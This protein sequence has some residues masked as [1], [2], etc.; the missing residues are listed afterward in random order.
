MVRSSFNETGFISNSSLVAYFDGT[1]N[2]ETNMEVVDAINGALPGVAHRFLHD[3]LYVGVA[4]CGYGDE[5]DE[6]LID[7]SQYNVSWLPDVKIYGVN[8]TVGTSLLR[9]QFGDRRDV[10]IALESMGNVLRMMLGGEDNNEEEYEEL[11]EPEDV[12]DGG[13]CQQTTPPEYQPDMDFEKLEKPDEVP[14]LEEN[15]EEDE[16][17]PELDKEEEKPKLDEGPRKPKLAGGE[18][19]AELDGGPRENKRIDRVAGFDS[20]ASKRRGGGALMGGGGGG[21]GGFIAG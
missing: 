12:G 15:K 13:S 7:C 3:G 9:G 1:G 19:R 6:K 4:N 18:T 5:D 10:Q 21:G 14:L 17:K 11:K 2:G 8:D 16:D 20:R